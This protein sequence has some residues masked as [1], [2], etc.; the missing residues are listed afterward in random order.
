MFLRATS[1]SIN[2]IT[3]NA[4]QNVS[5][6]LTLPSTSGSTGEVLTTNGSGVL[7]WSVPTETNY[8][9]TVGTI[10]N[11][12]GTGRVSKQL[13][14]SILDEQTRPIVDN[15]T[16]IT[17]NSFQL[18]GVTNLSSNCNS[19]AYSPEL[20]RYVAGS[21]GSSQP[22]YSTNGVTWTLAATSVGNCTSICWSPELKI[23]CALPGSGTGIST[24][25]DGITWTLRTGISATWS[26]ICWSPELSLFCAVGTNAIQ[27]SPDGITWTSRTPADTTAIQW[28]T[29]ASDLGLFVAC[30]SG[31]AVNR[32]ST[33]SDGVTWTLRTTPGSLGLSCVVFSAYLGLLI[34]HG[35][36]STNYYTS[37]DGITWTTRTTMPG[38]I[39]WRSSVWV[40][41]LYAFLIC[42]VGTVAYSFDGLTWYSVLLSSTP[43][44]SSMTFANRMAFSNSSLVL[45]PNTP[46]VNTVYTQ[47]QSLLSLNSTVVP[48]N[49]GGTGVSTIGTSGQYAIV[50]AGATGFTYTTGPGGGGVSQVGLAGDVDMNS[51]LTITS[52]SSNPITSAG[53]FTLTMNTAPVITGNTSIVG[54]LNVSGLTA[55][56]PVFTDGSKNLVS[57]GTNGTGNVVLTT[58]PTLVT[59]NIGAATGT[60]LVVTS[61]LTTN[62]GG[63]NA[64]TTGGNE[65]SQITSTTGGG[66]RLIGNSISGITSNYTIIAYAPA[67]ANFSTSAI[68]GDVVFSFVSN[69][70]RSLHFQTGTGAAALT[71]T[72]ANAVNMPGLTASLPVFTDGSKNL[73]SVGTNGTGNVVLTTSPTLI[74]PNIGDASGGTLNLSGLLTATTI[75]ASG[76]ITANAGLSSSLTSGSTPPATLTN[77]ASSITPFVPLIDMYAPTLGVARI[78]SMKLGASSTRLASLSFIRSASTEGQLVLTVLADTVSN[79]FTMYTN[80]AIPA[81]LSCALTVSGDFSA[82]AITASGLVSANAGLSATTISASGLVSANA[83]LTA[84]TITASTKIVCPTFETG[85]ALMLNEL[86]NVDSTFR[87][88]GVNVNLQIAGGVSGTTN[89]DMVVVSGPFVS[90]SAVANDFVLRAPN[91][92]HFQSGTGAS[93]ITIQTTTNDV[94]IRN[95]LFVGNSPFTFNTGTWTPA[96]TCLKANGGGTAYVNTTWDAEFGNSGSGFYTRC[97]NQVTVFFEVVTS[98]FGTNNDFLSGRRIPTI[99]NLPFKCITSGTGIDIIVSGIVSEQEFPNGYVAG[100]AAPLAITMD[101]N[102]QC[103]AYEENYVYDPKFPP[104]YASTLPWTSDGYTLVVSCAQSQY[105]VLGLTTFSGLD[106]PASNF[107]VLAGSGPYLANFKGSI[108]YFTE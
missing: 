46:G 51:F 67:A 64:T 65:F 50:N 29:W 104:L 4:P 69:P 8:I 35:G 14:L 43:S 28:V 58:S 108:T 88:K 55:S 107:N 90:T 32:I 16:P 24:S 53:T 86:V 56:L 42:G 85:A 38:G 6:T 98:Y 52:S 71:I 15:I 33:S 93:A 73:V 76:L 26:S 68:G 47:S 17:V 20:N 25:T 19:L 101:G 7:T 72:S 81:T 5:Y 23:F 22:S 78:A 80:P 1:L 75:T 10:L 96:S 45:A 36:T 30:A 34:A 54:D 41:W 87:V 37:S 91:N 44:G 102:W 94:I 39:Q 99:A 77:N 70:I 100:L 60:S 9:S 83:G 48:F 13:K 95:K 49:L 18:G 59:P 74:T 92:L 63:I 40:P 2:N 106:G 21:A 57:V 79:N 82:T 12:S 31:A 97:G 61:G 27:T 84:T 66:L 11:T 103:T 105:S 89:A 3:I 62:A